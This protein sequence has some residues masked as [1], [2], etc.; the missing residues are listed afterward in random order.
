MRRQSERAPSKWV[1]NQNPPDH[2][3]MRALMAPAFSPTHLAPLGSR[4]QAMADALLDRVQAAGRMDIVADF[5]D[6]LPAWVI[7]EMMGVSPADRDRLHRWARD[8]CLDFDL[9][10]TPMGRERMLLARA[11]FSEYA[12]SQITQPGQGAPSEL[13]SALLGA[14]A[15]GGLSTDELLANF[16]LLFFAGYGTTSTLI[17]NSMLALLRHPDQ[18]RRLQDEPALIAS[19]VEEL[20]RY[21]SPTQLA[22]REALDDVELDGLRFRKGER[23]VLMLGAANRDPERFIEPDRLD[24]GRTPNP[25][26]SFGQGIHFCLGAHV[27]R[28]EAQ[29]ALGTLVRR[30]PGLALEDRPLEWAPSLELRRL[31]ALPVRF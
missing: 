22:P 1:L 28:L 17:A 29:I 23:L 19:A 20:V 5:A 16:G 26:L 15:S 31:S 14:H 6:Q 21:D 24:L 27:A 13:M 12:R 18:M 2:T 3:R 4:I 9:T 10:P 8:S 7:S 30:L 25:H 11:G